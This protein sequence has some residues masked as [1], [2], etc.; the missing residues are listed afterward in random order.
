MA[1]KTDKRIENIKVIALYSIITIVTVGGTVYGVTRV[2]KVRKQ[3]NAQDNALQ[4]GSPEN[5]ANQ[6]YFAFQNTEA[7]WISM[8][9][10]WGTDTESLYKI[11][12]NDI[13]SKDHYTKVIKA[14]AALYKGRSLNGDLSS[15]LEN[16]PKV[17][18][19]LTKLLATKPQSTPRVKR[20]K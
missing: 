19:D 11:Y 13:K 7:W 6:L 18:T 20:V 12:Q 10:G 8:G 15:E 5:I 2:I 14:Y 16:E 17:Y 4:E 9:V 1:N 3:K